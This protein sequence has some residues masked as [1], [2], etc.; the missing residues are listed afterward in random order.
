MY[1]AIPP[2]P[3]RLYGVVFNQVMD[4]FFIAWYL[5]SRVYLEKLTVTQ[6][7]KKF[8]AIYGTHRFITI[9]QGPALVPILSYLHP[10][11][12]FLP[13]FPMIRSNII[14]PSAPRSS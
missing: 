7:V 12:N 8:P 9:S 6:L 5:W 10:V 1:E 2:L 11:H 4:V 3:I 14:L 13:H